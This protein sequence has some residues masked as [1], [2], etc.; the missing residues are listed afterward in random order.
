MLV[1]IAGGRAGESHISSLSFTVTEV[2]HSLLLW[3]P[4]Y[5][6][7]WALGFLYVTGWWWIARPFTLGAISHIAVDMLT[8]G[9]GKNFQGG[10]Y[11]WPRKWELGSKVGLWLYRDHAGIYIP[12]PFELVCIVLLLG[13]IY[14]QTLPWPKPAPTR[15]K[16]AAA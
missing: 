3:L 8:H 16:A 9:H 13:I 5:A 1:N 6:L 4:L 2:T 12:K 11:F 7:S 14:R 10:L 15:A